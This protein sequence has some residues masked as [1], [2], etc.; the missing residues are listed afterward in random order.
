MAIMILSTIF[1]ASQADVFADTTINVTAEEMLTVAVTMPETQASGDGSASGTFLRNKVALA[2]TTNNATGFTATMTTSTVDT[3]LTN[4]IDEIPILTAN[5]TRGAFPSNYWGYSINDA[6]TNAGD[7]SST[8][9][10]I[11]ALGAS[12]PSY[13]TNSPSSSSTVTKNIFFGA[14]AN[15][16]K[17]SGTYSNTVIISVVSGVNDTEN[18]NPTTPTNPVH[19]SDD[20]SSDGTATFKPSP[21]G[22]SNTGATVYTKQN[23]TT[24]GTTI[25]SGDTTGATYANPAGVTTVS[26]VGEGTPLATGLAVTAGVAATAGVIFFIVA[27]RRRDDEDEEDYE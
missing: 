22:G 24:T 14:K 6:D 12:V 27:K 23:G 3:D 21:A 4:G 9:R 7:S 10:P 8:Y 16:S 1:M 2:V 25:T 18:Q 19:P 5:T 20:D 17:S 13:I 11:A 26:S 15:L